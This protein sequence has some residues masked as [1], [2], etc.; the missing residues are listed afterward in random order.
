MQG[1]IRFS[2]SPSILSKGGLLKTSRTLNG[3]LK[4]ISK[5]TFLAGAVPLFHIMKSWEAALSVIK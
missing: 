5:P 3:G 1:D 2:F 4:E